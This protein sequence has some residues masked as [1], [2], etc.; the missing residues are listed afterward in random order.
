MS[1]TVSAQAITK[2]FGGRPALDGVDLDIETGS[3]LALL[4]PNGAGKTT[5]V[6]ILATLTRP[7]SGT[8]TVAGHDLLTDPAAVKRRVSLTGQFVALDEVLTGARE[9]RDDGPAAASPACTRAG[10][11]RPAAG[12]VRPAAT[13]PTAASARTPAA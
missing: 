7:D 5:M 13:P 2:S 3:V 1:Y 12:G 9:P 6:R 4:G 11:G 8:A 10:A